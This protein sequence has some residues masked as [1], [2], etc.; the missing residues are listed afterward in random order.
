M[1]DTQKTIIILGI[2]ALVYFVF[3]KPVSYTHAWQEKEIIYIP[4]ERGFGA[5]TSGRDNKP[6]EQTVI[7][8]RQEQRIA[9]ETTALRAVVVFLVTVGLFTAFK[10]PE[11]KGGG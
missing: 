2:I 5:A 11:N 6:R 3:I 8:N 1:N 9:V 7:H 10:T 4:A